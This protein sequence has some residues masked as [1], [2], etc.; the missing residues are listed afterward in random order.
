MHYEIHSFFHNNT[1][2]ISNWCPKRDSNSHTFRYQNLNLECL[3]IPP[4][5]QNTFYTFIILSIL[6][7]VYNCSLNTTW[8]IPTQNISCY[9]YTLSRNINR[10]YVRLLLQSS[11]PILYS[12]NLITSSFQTGRGLK[13]QTLKY[14]NVNFGRGCRDRTYAWRNQNLLPYLLASP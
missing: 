6:G 10:L 3:P 13:S 12:S 1:T 7:Y 14:L 4:S 5:G 11:N 8:K 2:N 9:T